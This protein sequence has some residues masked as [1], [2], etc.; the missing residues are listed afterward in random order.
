M[1]T[2]LV[3]TASHVKALRDALLQHDERERFAFMYCSWSGSDR[4]VPVEVHPVAD[5]D[6]ATMQRTACRPELKVE[7][8]HIDQCLDRGLVPLLVHSHP[9]SGDP[10]FSGQDQRIMSKQT[11]WLQQLY[12]GQEIGFAV[13]GTSGISALLEH[14][15]TGSIQLS[16]DVIGAWK[17]NTPVTE[18]QPSMPTSVNRERYDRN[19]RL[20]TLEGQ[21]QLHELSVAVVGV[22]G[23]GSM[24]AVQLARL[25]VH[26]LTLVDPDMVE[27]SNL[28]RL[29][30][31]SEGDIGRAKVDVVHQ[32][33]FE[34]NPDTEVTAVASRVQDAVDV[35]ED[36][37]VILGCVD[38]MSARVFLNEYAVKHLRLYIDGG[39]RID[40]DGGTVEAMDGYVQ[41]VAP[42][43][44]ACFDC[45]GRSSPEI[46]R[47]E[48]LSDD[49]LEQEVQ[50]GYIDEQELVPEPAVVYL[51]GVAASL[52][53]SQ[54]AKVATGYVGPSE[55]IRFDALQDET[56]SVVTEPADGCVTCTRMLGRGEYSPSEYATLA[57]KLG[58]AETEV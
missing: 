25:G 15:E 13:V 28:P 44:S 24:A 20:F 43:A 52:L 46:L 51:N 50:R 2:R 6:M 37:D 1:T 54:V 12:P 53:V 42:G 17:L 31:A 41:V 57:D 30:G 58:S 23:L 33:V 8:S 11:E 47:R 4:L 22:G 56:S 48:L 49:E 14:P 55:F 5:D 45:L 34:A 3:L 40:V 21:E 18:D 38:R 36:V 10:S 32:A 7:R 9:F 29:S 19:T 35:L 27:R 39:S 16:V 26:D